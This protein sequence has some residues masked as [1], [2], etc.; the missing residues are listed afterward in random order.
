V[1]GLPALEAL[2]DALPASGLG[3][4]HPV[5]DLAHALLH[6]LE[7]VGQHFS[8]EGGAGPLGV[9]E[10]EE[11]DRAQRP[12]E[13]VAASPVELE[14]HLLHLGEA[15]AEVAGL[16]LAVAGELRFHLLQ[17]REVLLQQ[18][19]P[20]ADPALRLVDV[21][22]VLQDVDLVEGHHHLL[23]PGAD[24]LQEGPLALREGAIGGGH[25]EHEV[26][27]GNELA[28]EG[29]V[30]A[31]DGVRPRGV[32]DGDLAEDGQ[33]QGDH[34]EPPAGGSAA[35]VGPVPQEADAVGRGGD[36]LLE[37][38][39]AEKGVD[40]RALAGV[41]LSHHHEQEQLVELG[42]GA[43]EGLLALR[44]GLEAD[45]RHPQLAQ[46]PPLLLQEPLSRLVEDPPQH[47]SLPAV[48][49]R[50]GSAGAAVWPRDR[51]APRWGS[52]KPPGRR[53]L[54]GWPPR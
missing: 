46:E 19:E 41:E 54:Q 14:E 39:L 33:G 18:R 2:G 4:G 9:Q 36:A 1:N 29:F 23:P 37:H 24:H 50:P 5:R 53:S 44:R 15:E 16:L 7:Q 20:L 17:G 12:A 11:P 21:G 30:V 48:R 40:H 13:E 3:P 47:A 42:D 25:E 10:L 31:Q 45:E 52:P 32:H 35:R 8:L 49:S 6:D 43:G 22:L 38:P 34:L 26:R 28:G 27:A 51:G